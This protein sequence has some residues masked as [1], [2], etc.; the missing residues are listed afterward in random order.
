M[1]MVIALIAGSGCLTSSPAVSP[2][3][4]G[5]SSSVSPVQPG[6]EGR[7]QVITI[8][9]GVKSPYILGKSAA[10]MPAAKKAANDLGIEI[11]A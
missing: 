9:T 2:S 1:A 10:R 4:P 3:D 7:V 6:Q 11:L 8:I 5:V